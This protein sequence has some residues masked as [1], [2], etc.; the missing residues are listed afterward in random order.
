MIIKFA[1]AGAALALGLAGQVQAQ[2]WTG[3]YAGL[4]ASSA[5]S[6]QTLV[7]AGQDY[8]GSDTS[9]GI[10]GGYNHQLANNIV[11][12]GELSYGLGDS[13][14]FAGG[15]ELGMENMVQVRARMGYAMDNVMPYLAAGYA[16]AD[17]SVG[18]TPF[19]GLEDSGYNLGVGLEYMFTEKL[20]ARVEYSVTQFD[21]VL[22]P[23]YGPGTWD[24][25][26]EAISF[27]MGWHF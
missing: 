22:S 5:T 1:A 12:G 4:S 27:G 20:S 8:N 15:A 13:G 6:T 21:D 16:Q 23:P 14:V 11:L 10:Y 25:K 7:P 9:L 26:H 18:G 24:R 3:F 17:F 2:D 19:Q